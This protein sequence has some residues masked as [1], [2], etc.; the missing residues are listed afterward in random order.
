MTAPLSHLA[1]TKWELKQSDRCPSHSD[2]YC[3]SLL[4]F[5]DKT[6]QFTMMHPVDEKLVT[7]TYDADLAR[8]ACH[9]LKDGAMGQRFPFTGN[10][11]EN[12]TLET[13]AKVIYVELQTEK[14]TYVPE[15]TR[16]NAQLFAGLVFAGLFLA[17]LMYL[18]E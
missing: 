18:N 2:E 12:G 17:L 6:S 7:Y 9:V 1:G 3:A 16:K 8:H 5:D 13:F 10:G 15:G 4:Q 14:V 11:G